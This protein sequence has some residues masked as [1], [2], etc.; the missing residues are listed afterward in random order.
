MLGVEALGVGQ[1][2]S[3]VFKQQSNDRDRA[4]LTG[5]IQ[6]HMVGI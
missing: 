2:L 3:P 6:G 4:A 5:E 1:N